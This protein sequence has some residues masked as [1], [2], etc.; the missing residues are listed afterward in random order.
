MGKM[1]K[2]LKKAQQAQV[3]SASTATAAAPAADHAG[4]ATPRSAAERPS[5]VAI[6]NTFRTDL[7]P[8]LVALV[9][10]TGQHAQ[11][12]RVLARNLD[13]LGEETPITSIVAP[14]LS[15]SSFSSRT[16]ISARSVWLEERLSSNS[17]LSSPPCTSVVMYPW[18]LSSAW[19][20]SR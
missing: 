1:Q 15:S 16:S 9:D 19:I 2:A 13:R 8:H 14:P 12:Y 20:T 7:D 6:S 4:A 10:P 3:K 17:I 11:Q 18:R 5:V